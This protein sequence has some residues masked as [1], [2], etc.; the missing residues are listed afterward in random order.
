MLMS[1]AQSRFANAVASAGTR[2]TAPPCVKSAI[3][4]ERRR[5]PFGLGDDV[6]IVI[7]GERP[8]L[9]RLP[10]VVPPVRQ[11]RVEHLLVRDVRLRHDAVDR[12]RAELVEER[13]STFCRRRSGLRR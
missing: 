11:R 13:L 7:V 8:E 4:R 5:D 1:W 3:A 9:V 2:A 6:S 10:V 12:G